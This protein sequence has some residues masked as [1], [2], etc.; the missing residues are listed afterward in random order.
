[1]GPPKLPG[2]MAGQPGEHRKFFPRRGMSPLLCTGVFSQRGGPIFSPNPAGNGKH[3]SSHRRKKVGAVF[4]IPDFMEIQTPRAQ[5]ARSDGGTIW[6]A[7]KIFLPARAD[8]PVIHRRIFAA[9]RPCSSP[10]SRMG[11]EYKTPTSFAKGGS[12]FYKGRTNG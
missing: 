11:W 3:K 6:K 1:M 2:A 12:N 7:R 8:S 10:Q 4:Y 9:G 5:T